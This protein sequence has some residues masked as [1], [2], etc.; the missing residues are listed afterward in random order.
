MER[1]IRL[2]NYEQGTHAVYDRVLDKQ[3]TNEEILELEK[4]FHNHNNEINKIL[5]L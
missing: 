2:V 3:L 5:N 4:E 1:Y